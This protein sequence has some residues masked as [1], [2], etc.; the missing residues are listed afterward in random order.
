[1]SHKSQ[2]ITKQKAPSE[3]SD[4]PVGAGGVLAEGASADALVLALAAGNSYFTNKHTQIQNRYIKKQ[5]K[6]KQIRK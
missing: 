6:T 2:S 4:A 3:P 5:N 1:M